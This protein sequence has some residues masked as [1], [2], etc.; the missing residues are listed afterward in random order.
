[1]LRRRYGLQ[2]CGQNRADVRERH[3][4]ACGEV[5]PGVHVEGVIAHIHA[6]K[7]AGDV[8]VVG[9][10]VVVVVVQRSDR[11]PAHAAGPLQG[12]QSRGEGAAVP[13]GQEVLVVAGC[14]DAQRGRERAG[15]GFG[16]RGA[17]GIYER[18][19]GF[20]VESGQVTGHDDDDVDLTRQQRQPRRDPRHGPGMRWLLAGVAARTNRD[21]RARDRP[22]GAQ[23][24]LDH[25]L[26]G[27][28]EPG[29]VHAAQPARA[30]AGEHNR[31]D[32]DRCS[33]PVHGWLFG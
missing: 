8:V 17:H 26:S 2:S 27:H 3:R 4:T 14:V 29:F 16:A 24:C 28:R 1:M 31:A 10:V 7:G 33:V 22:R 15:C 13:R 19:Q 11:S 25:R 21:D 12:V 9:G 30:A 32:L 6:E 18:G 23:D 20:G 5:G